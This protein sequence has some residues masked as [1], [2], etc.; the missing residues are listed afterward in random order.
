M[1][2][3]VYGRSV[4]E[5]S[6][7]IATSNN[8]DPNVVGQGFYAR[9]TGANAEVISMWHIMMFGKRPFYVENGNLICR[10]KPVLKAEFFDRNNEVSSTFL[11]KTQVTYVNAQRKNT[12]DGDCSVEKIELYAK[13]NKKIINGDKIFGEEAEKVRNNEYD[14]IK[15]YL[16]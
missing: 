7:F 16:R 12:Y 11:G 5:N 4:L 6:S 10:L 9:L 8:P 14:S 13:D 15:I 2:A 1:K 3:E